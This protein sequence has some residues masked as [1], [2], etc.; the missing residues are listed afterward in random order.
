MKRA[1]TEIVQAP[2][3][4]T[5]TNADGC[6]SRFQQI[7][8][9]KPERLGST[10][11][12]PKASAA[13]GNSILTAGHLF[14]GAIQPRAI[15]YPIMSPATAPHATV[16]NV[17]S[18]PQRSGVSP[19]LT[20]G[21]CSIHHDYGND[22]SVELWPDMMSPCA[23]GR[24]TVASFAHSPRLTGCNTTVTYRNGQNALAYILEATDDS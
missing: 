17:A 23:C 14:F 15:G 3:N 5:R 12:I 16:P 8:E 10:S 22:H 6:D 4:Q 24:H 2:V 21:Q 13:V 18:E 7:S 11:E 9:P 20:A 1:S 19:S